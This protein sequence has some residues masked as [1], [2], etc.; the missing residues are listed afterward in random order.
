MP[1]LDSRMFPHST[2][3][4]KSRPILGTYVDFGI[5]RYQRT[6][7]TIAQINAGFTL[8]PALPG[9]RWRLTD[10][11][12]VAVGGAVA[13]ATDVRILGTR[14]AASV[15]LAVTAVAALGQSVVT[16][17]GVSNAVVLA[18][19]ASFTQLDVNT[20]ITCGK[21]GSTATTATHVDIIL[22]YVADPA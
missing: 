18:D 14:A 10:W 22:R 21:T 6:R 17:A 13:A 8:L 11:T 12:M 5:E 1:L 4:P 9:V 16:R 20:A 2:G 19:N 3:A 15:A 7:V